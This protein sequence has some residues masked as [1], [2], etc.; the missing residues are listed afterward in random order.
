M[1][2]DI[3]SEYKINSRTK[4]IVSI[5]GIQYI[6]GELNKVINKNSQDN[7][8]NVMSLKNIPKI[9]PIKTEWKYK[10]FFITINLINKKNKTKLIEI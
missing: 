3:S 8:E 9:L 7:T 6:N 10:E 4:I 2:G 5:I 1:V